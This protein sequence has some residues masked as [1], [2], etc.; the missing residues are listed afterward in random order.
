M[1]DTAD[2][3]DNENRR[4][5]LQLTAAGMGAVGAVAAAAPLV[6]SLNPAADTLA[7]ST[8]EVDISGIPVGESRT[9]FWQGKPVFIRHRTEEEIKEAQDVDVSALSDKQTDEERVQ[10]PEWLIAVGIC[11]HLGCSPSF[12]QGGFGEKVEGTDDG[13]FCPC[14][15]SKFDMAGR[16]FQS[17]PAPLNL[18]IP[19][20]TFLDDTTILVGEEK[21]V[22]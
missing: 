7:L 3:A 4:D 16:V 6:N 21:G 9:V 17:V 1:T 14:H 5:F 8:I 19:P 13:F 2:K 12:L 22:A 11:T 20:Y 18:E 15:G 10:K